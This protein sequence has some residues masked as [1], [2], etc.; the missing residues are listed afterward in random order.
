MRKRVGAPDSGIGLMAERKR[1]V[2]KP[3]VPCVADDDIAEL[4]RRYPKQAT[5]EDD[6]AINEKGELKG[7]QLQM[8]KLQTE[9]KIRQAKMINMIEKEL[10]KY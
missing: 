4:C 6:N 5:E 3:G 2:L 1:E 9:A 10:S 8:H 7:T